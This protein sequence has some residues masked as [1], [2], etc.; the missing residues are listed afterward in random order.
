MTVHNGRKLNTMTG[1]SRPFPDTEYKSFTP[2]QIAQAI[3]KITYSFG[4]E[5]LLTFY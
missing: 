2:V 3:D 1:S 5:Y 4:S